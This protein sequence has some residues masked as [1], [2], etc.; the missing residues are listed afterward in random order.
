M[1]GGTTA[2]DDEGGGGNSAKGAASTKKSMATMTVPVAPGGRARPTMLRR[3]AGASV[4]WDGGGTAVVR[5]A[6]RQ[7][8]KGERAVRRRARSESGPVCGGVSGDVSDRSRGRSREWECEARRSA[9]AGRALS[10]DRGPVIGPE[11]GTLSDIATGPV[12][13]LVNS[14]GH[15]TSIRSSLEF[16][17]SLHEWAWS[18]QPSLLPSRVT[19]PSTNCTNV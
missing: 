3:K 6:E 19:I 4:C 15:S 13:R 5:G 17:E 14:V 12:T 8:M 9:W 7:T 1:Q 10:V 11:H 16:G 18:E 2:D